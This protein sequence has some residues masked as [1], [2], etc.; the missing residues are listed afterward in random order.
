MFFPFP[1]LFYLAFGW[2]TLKP[3]HSLLLALCILG[4]GTLI[5]A[6]TEYLQGFLPYRTA[7]KADFGADFLALCCSTAITFLIDLNKTKRHA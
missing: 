2:S 7:D 3:W 1:I 6:G 4:I 5:S